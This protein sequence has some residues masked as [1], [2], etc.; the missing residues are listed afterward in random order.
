MFLYNIG[1][2]QKVINPHFKAWTFLFPL[3]RTLTAQLMIRVRFACLPEKSIG[4]VVCCL[5]QCDLPGAGFEVSESE[6]M[7]S[8]LSWRGCICG[9]QKPECRKLVVP[10]ALEVSAN[11]DVDTG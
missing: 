1:E 6:T 9:S 5:G 8:A 3:T 4:K 10:R 2:T 11:R 7:F